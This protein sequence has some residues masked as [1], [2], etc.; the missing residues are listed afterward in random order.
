MTSSTKTEV[1]FST[2]AGEGTNHG[3]VYLVLTTENLVKLGDIVLEK[4]ERTDRE[5]ALSQYSAPLRTAK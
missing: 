3:R 1:R 2:A 5:N 4:S